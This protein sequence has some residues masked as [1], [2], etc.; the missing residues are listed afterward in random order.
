MVK[1]NGLY[2]DGYLEKI[3]DNI[4]IKRFKHNYDNLIIVNGGEGTGKS[5]FAIGLCALYAHK[6]GI[7]FSV[8][9]I[10]FSGKEMV[11]LASSKKQS[12]ILYDEAI[13]G[14]MGAQWQNKTQQTIIQALMMARK[15]NN[16]FVLCVPAFERLNPYLVYD[17]AI[18]LIDI[19]TKGYKRGYASI[20]NKKKIRQYY[21]MKKAKK[22]KKPKPVFQIRF[23][24][25][26]KA[27]IDKPAYEEKKDQAIML[28]ND[29]LDTQKKSLHEKRMYQLIRYYDPKPI[30]LAKIFSISERKAYEWRR[31]TK[32]WAAENDAASQLT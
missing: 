5:S 18:L 27:V 4:L 15:N 24:D 10:T 19:Y 29:R 17:R 1:I 30:E 20:Y 6:L 32:L 14:L 22:D 26:S 13:Q 9:N 2:Y 7:D 31:K 12:I 3:V 21:D 28:L 16:L 23:S 11:G 8:D 25:H